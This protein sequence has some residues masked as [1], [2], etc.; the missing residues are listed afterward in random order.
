M[1]KNIASFLDEAL[2]EKLGKGEQGLAH[3]SSLK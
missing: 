3:V 1:G 2:I